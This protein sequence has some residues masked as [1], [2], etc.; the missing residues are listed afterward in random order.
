MAIL[1]T[2]LGNRS[3]WKINWQKKCSWFSVRMFVLAQGTGRWW[4]LLSAAVQIYA[5]LKCLPICSLSLTLRDWLFQNLLV[6]V[7]VQFMKSWIAMYFFFS[8]LT[9]LFFV[10]PCSVWDS[11]LAI[12]NAFFCPS[13]TF[14]MTVLHRSFAGLH[15]VWSHVTCPRKTVFSP[16]EDFFSFISAPAQPF[17][18]FKTNLIARFLVCVFAVSVHYSRVLLAPKMLLVSWFQHRAGLVSSVLNA[19]LQFAAGCRW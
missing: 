14:L 15:T 19:V 1:W 12:S 17:S 2:G 16:N 4:D 9:Y 10:L 11:I 13:R 7:W 8:S 6:K 18:S 3:I 5:S